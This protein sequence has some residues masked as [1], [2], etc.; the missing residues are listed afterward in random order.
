MKSASHTIVVGNLAAAHFVSDDGNNVIFVVENILSPHVLAID[1]VRDVSGGLG[2]A[3]LAG[4]FALRLDVAKDVVGRFVWVAAGACRAGGV[5]LDAGHI[6][7]VTR[8]ALV[9]AA[10]FGR[11]SECEE[12]EGGG[13][14][15]VGKK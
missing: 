3:H 10:S 15:Y 2:D 12:G 4:V 7:A 6:V 13:E 1:V 5:L 9:E 11:G 8:G 14:L